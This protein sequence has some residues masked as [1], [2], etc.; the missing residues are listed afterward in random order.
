MGELTRADLDRA[1]RDML[2]A[3]LPPASCPK[4]RRPVFVGGG[5]TPE[6]PCLD[7]RGAHIA[8]WTHF[9]ERFRGLVDGEGVPIIWERVDPA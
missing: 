6:G 3:A 8:E 5:G 1:Y 7:C 4:C 9:G 2:S